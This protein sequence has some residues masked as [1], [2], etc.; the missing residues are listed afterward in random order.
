MNAIINFYQI[1]KKDFIFLYPHHMPSVEESEK[2]DEQEEKEKNEEEVWIEAPL[3]LSKASKARWCHRPTICIFISD[4][5]NSDNQIIL[6]DEQAC[7]SKAATE[8]DKGESSLSFSLSVLPDSSRRQNW[9]RSCVWRPANGS[10]ASK[11][12][13]SY[14][15]NLTKRTTQSNWNDKW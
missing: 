2:E 3:H 13:Q 15:D 6:W 9:P 11:L 12:E 5:T 1:Q 4:L 10:R 14:P 7:L 8:K